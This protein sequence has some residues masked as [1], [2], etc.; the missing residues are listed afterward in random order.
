MAHPHHIYISLLK[1][2]LFCTLYSQTTAKGFAIVMSV[3]HAQST[4]H[5]NLANNIAK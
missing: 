3:R 5:S 2:L 4:E 1:V